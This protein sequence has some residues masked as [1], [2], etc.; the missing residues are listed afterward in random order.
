M[1]RVAFTSIEMKTSSIDVLH[2]SSFFEPPAQASASCVFLLS[3]LTTRSLSCSLLSPPC[4]RW[5][6]RFTL[7]EADPSST[8][9]PSLPRLSEPCGF[10]QE[11]LGRHTPSSTHVLAGPGWRNIKGTVSSTLEDV[12]LQ[13]QEV[14]DGGQDFISAQTH[15]MGSREKMGLNESQEEV[16]LSPVQCFSCPG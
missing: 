6:S 4:D 5:F 1:P 2:T 14:R 3:G 16:N 7:S 12:L 13:V 15:D 11:A 9:F 10:I 8:R